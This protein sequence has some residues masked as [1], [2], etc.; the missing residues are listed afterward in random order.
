MKKQKNS[1]IMHKINNL[2]NV[3]SHEWPRIILAWFLKF[4]IQTSYIMAGTL[5]VALFV[6]KFS[7]VNLPYL[8]IISSVFVISGT[9]LFSMFLERFSLKSEILAMV[10]LVSLLFFLIPSLQNSFVIFFLLLFFTVSICIEQLLIILALYIEELFSPLESERTFPIIESSEPIAGIFSGVVLAYGVTFLNLTALEIFYLVGFF[11]FLTIPVFFFFYKYTKKIPKLESKEEKKERSHNRIEKIKKGVRHIKGL[12]FLKGLFVVVFLHFALVNL[13][14]YEYTTIVD[15]NLKHHQEENIDKVKESSNSSHADQLTHGLGFFH[16]MFSLLAFFAQLLSASRIQS[17]LGVIKSMMS[18]PIANIFSGIIIF[19]GFF[20][21]FLIYES[22][23]FARGLFELTNIFHRTN[24]HASFYVLKKSIREQ[25]KEFM[26]GIVRP[27]GKILGTIVLL[28]ILTFVPKEFQT[29]VI[30]GVFVTGMVYMFYILKDM[31]I[32]YTLLAKKNLISKNSNIDKLESLE[33]LAQKGHHNVVEIFTKT[34]HQKTHPYLKKELL[35]T[36]GKIKDLKSIPD[37]LKMFKDPD[38]KI[39]LT[40]VNSLAQY[41]NL[42]RH[43]FSQSFTK[44]RVINDLQELFLKT[45][46]KKI[47]SAVIR[48]FKNI[49]HSD[50]IPFL[51]KN[52]DNNDPYIVAD[53]IYVCGLFHDINSAYYLEKFLTDKNPRIRSSAIIALWNF[54]TYKLKCLIQLNAM[55]E[56][57]LEEEKISAIYA[58]GEIGAIQEIPR[59]I[60][61]AENTEGRIHQHSLIALA[62]MEQNQVVNE[63]LPYLLHKDEDLVNDTKKMLKKVPESIKKTI[64]NLLLHEISHRIYEILSTLKSTE[65]ENVKTNVLYKLKKYYELISEVKEVLRIEEELIRR[66]KDV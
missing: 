46:S 47:K 22:V 56:S 14:E 32:Q 40:A 30:S 48:V 6:E 29:K 31:K 28:L 52:L 59:L 23:I 18:H 16:I 11:L 26:E 24:Y 12:N 5:I 2:L 42:G 4:F 64:E 8:Y 35:L 55:L 37:I 13:I 44:H 60:K 20:Y 15:K 3:S 21:N 53:A 63:I 62:K 51:L 65:I 34:L 39:Q 54:S 19:L 66:K 50:I 9:V 27:L 61:L 7:T 49:H 45:R 38:K 10:P 25:V 58:I 57:S 1:K 17:K 36:I 43:F 33:I 41:K